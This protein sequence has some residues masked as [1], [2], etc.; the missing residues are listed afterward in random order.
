MSTRHA[1]VRALDYFR[2][3]SHSRFCKA[4]RKL[5][6]GLESPTPQG[7]GQRFPAI[8]HCSHVTGDYGVVM[9]NPT[10]TRCV[11]CAV[12]CAVIL[13]AS[14]SRPP[15]P[16]LVDVRGREDLSSF[17]L[18]QVRGTRDGDRLDA[19]ATFGDGASTLT[20]NLHF[21][22]GSPTTLTSGEWSWMRNGKLA[23]GSVEPQ[24]VM[25]LG[26][27][28]GPPSVGGTYDLLDSAG[29]AVYRISIPTTEL[30]EKLR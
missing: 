20:V 5:G 8:G 26:G 6:C 14:C 23:A 18:E 1:G 7:A 16:P 30:R 21:A 2:P 12:C 15:K 22:V 10:V 9:P 27:Q 19:R 25:F 13:I 17:K 11:G 24:S 3:H 4:E 28:D 29:A